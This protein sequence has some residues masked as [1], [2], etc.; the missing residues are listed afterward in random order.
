MLGLSSNQMSMMTSPLRF[1]LVV[2]C[3][4]AATSGVLAQYSW[5]PLAIPRAQA[6]YDDMY[7]HSPQL[8]W[9]IDFA[10]SMQKTVDG[11]QSWQTLPGPGGSGYRSIGF[12]TDQIGFMGK[13]GRN[14]TT[15]DTFA[16]Y[17]TTDGGQAW[18][19]V[20]L[21]GSGSRRGFCGMSVVNDSVM[22]ACGRYLGP[23][24]VYRTTDAGQ[25][26]QTIDLTAYAGGLVDCYFW[27]VDSGMVVGCT[28]GYNNSYGLV[29][30][31]SDGGATWTERYRT[32]QVAD[33]CWKITFP[34]PRTGYISI[35]DFNGGALRCLK[36]TDH[37]QTWREVLIASN[38]VFN[39]EGI[40]FI[41]DSVG[42]VGGNYLSPEVY[43]TTD[44]GRSWILNS[45]YA[46]LNR[47]RFFGDTLGYA[48]GD[49]VY[50]ITPQAVGLPGLLPAASGVVG[51]CYPNPVVNGR[52]SLPITLRARGTVT[53][54]LTDV[55][56][57]EIV[58]R[59]TTVAAGAQ[60]VPLPVEG[61][62][63][64]LYFC[65]VQTPSGEQVRRVMVQR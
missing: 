58:R 57:R 45:L 14:T 44:G 4:F 2:A 3:F 24:F 28:G 7:W 50:R 40:G 9:A 46:N 62:C 1:L 39:S 17:K 64:G 38:T 43:S 35:E 19:G 26:W 36:T 21:P 20:Q 31:T 13:L 29:L 65:R 53:L 55:L 48:S 11:G 33:L 15:A 41:N 49:F 22:V 5:Q 30:G 47:F 8:G 60:A 37:G 54:R 59:T 18:T 56:G 27:S 12:M 34:T 25:T 16:L 23:A 52:A 10:G 51:E 42:W 32:T 6:R 63:T 61:L